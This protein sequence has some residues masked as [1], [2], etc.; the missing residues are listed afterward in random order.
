MAASGCNTDLKTFDLADAPIHLVASEND[1]VVLFSC[2]TNTE[3]R[4]R[5]VG[6]TVET[7]YFMGDG[8]HALQLYNKNQAAVDAAWTAF[9]LRHLGLP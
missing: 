3:Q 8:T 1:A 4:T 9:L 6:G 7:L 2:V 5:D